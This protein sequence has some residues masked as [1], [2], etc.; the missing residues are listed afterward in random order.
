VSDVRLRDVIETDLPI[1]FEH[2]REPEAVRMAAFPSRDRDAFF[3]HWTTNILG[4]ERVARKTI[5]CDG[6][7]AGNIV[8][9][10]HSGRPLVGYWIGKE[11]WGRGIATH[12]LSEFVREVR[13]RPLY[14][15]VAKSNVGSIRVLEKCGFRRSSEETSGAD[16]VEEV[17]MELGPAA[18]SPSRPS[19]L[20]D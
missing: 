2:Q 8:S 20:L 19:A 12:A 15:R 5:L 3:L 10:E 17:V 14:A 1:L 7:V 18:D 13:R 9:W 4:N 16:G 11:F 6:R